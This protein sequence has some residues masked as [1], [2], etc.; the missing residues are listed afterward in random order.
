MKFV[1]AVL[2]SAEIQKIQKEFGDYVKLTIDLESRRI[3]VGSDL[4]IDGEK[5]LLEKGGNGDDIWGG[6]ID[7]KDKI[8]DTTAVLNLRPRLNNESMEILDPER[9]TKFV[10]IVKDYFKELWH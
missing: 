1:D 5:L 7:L 3:V 8:I 2:S 9:R 4:H 6:G 10:E